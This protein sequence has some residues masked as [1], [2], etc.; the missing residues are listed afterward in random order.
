VHAAGSGV[1]SSL[2]EQAN[3]RHQHTTSTATAHGTPAH[4]QQPPAYGAQPA[5]T[6]SISNDQ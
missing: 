1:T 4:Q 2:S 3:P 6:T 5:P